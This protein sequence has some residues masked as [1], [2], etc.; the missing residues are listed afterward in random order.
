MAARADS[1]G[2]RA[3]PEALPQPLSIAFV[4]SGQAAASMARALRG[5]RGRHRLSIVER[6]QAAHVLARDVRGRIIGAR[7]ALAGCDLVLL[8]IPD[9]A[10]AGVAAALAERSSGGAVV[11]HLSGSAGLEV[12]DSL[13]AVG[14][15]VGA[16]HPLQVLSGWR[17][18]PGTTFAV[19][20]SGR[21]RLLL[22]RLV[23]DLSGVELEIPRGARAAYHAAAVIAANLGMTLLAE[24]VD[25]MQAAGIDRDRALDGLTGLVRGGLEASLERGLP[26]GITGPLSRG[27][28]ETVRAHLGV[29]KADRELSRSYR[30][31]SRL[32]LRQLERDGRPAPAAASGL[33]RL[34]EEPE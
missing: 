6:G 16:I 10:I 19:E 5:S 9:A 25:L 20:G 27:D 34:L 26:A 3:A 13:Q 30:S 8:A 32:A 15:E 17:I 33:R 4:G 12:L 24:A 11:A 29:I 21:A 31:V 28:L 18:P 2:L 1:A 22:S 23:G 14:H 7:D